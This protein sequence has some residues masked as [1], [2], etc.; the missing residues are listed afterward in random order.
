MTGGRRRREPASARHAAK[1]AGKT[2]RRT[3]VVELSHHQP[4]VGRSEPVPDLGHDGHG[5]VLCCLWGG[6]GKGMSVN[7]AMRVRRGGL[8][9]LL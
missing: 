2:A 6:S 3:V 7:E 9:C 5:C 4:G 8:V 1:P